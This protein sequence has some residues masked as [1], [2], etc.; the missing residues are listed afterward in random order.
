MYHHL[1]HLINLQSFGF[2]FY[3]LS[4]IKLNQTTVTEFCGK[5]KVVSSDFFN[6]KEH[7]SLHQ[8]HQHN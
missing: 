1:C 3:I 2:P 6:D 7:C 4:I 8:V 5:S